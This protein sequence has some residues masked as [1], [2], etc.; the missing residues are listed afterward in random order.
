ML[1]VNPYSVCST[2]L[3]YHTELFASLHSPKKKCQFRTNSIIEMVTCIQSTEAESF[4]TCQIITRTQHR[5]AKTERS[6]FKL[7]L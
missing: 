3:E 6:R 7:K 5:P 2:L 4:G 1:F